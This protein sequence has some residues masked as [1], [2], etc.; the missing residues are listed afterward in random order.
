L[1]WIKSP[2]DIINSRNINI[3]EMQMCTTPPELSNSNRTIRN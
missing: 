2:E 1:L 3:E